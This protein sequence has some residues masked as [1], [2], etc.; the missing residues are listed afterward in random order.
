M[1]VIIHEYVR[2]SEMFPPFNSAHEGYAVILEELDELKAEVWKNQNNRDAAKM[3]KE[4]VH[5]AAMALRFIVDLCPFE[6]KES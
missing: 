3:M 4:A 5:V 1:T 6:I 2:A